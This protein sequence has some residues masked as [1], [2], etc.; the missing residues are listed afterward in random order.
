VP[1]S[2]FIRRHFQAYGD[3]TRYAVSQRPLTL[4]T[5]GNQSGLKIAK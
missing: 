1:S 4:Q 3:L 5:A 2:F